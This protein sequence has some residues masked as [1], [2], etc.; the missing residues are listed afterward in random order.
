MRF[1]YTINPRK[2]T[3]FLGIVSLYLAV[4]SLIGEYLLENVLSSETDSLIVPLLDLFSVNAEETIP[5]WYST[6]LLFFGAALL[7][8]IAAVKQKNRVSLDG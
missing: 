8:F 4:Q 7:A 3:L 6:L 5:T 1:K 2:S